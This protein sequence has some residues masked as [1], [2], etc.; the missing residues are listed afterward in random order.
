MAIKDGPNHVSVMPTLPFTMK[1][2]IDFR[3]NA[4]T[5]SHAYTRLL[6]AICW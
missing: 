5:S 2:W 3:P 4:N 6:K 1:S